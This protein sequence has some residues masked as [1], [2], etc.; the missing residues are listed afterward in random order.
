M[1]EWI[2][3]FPLAVVLF[4]NSALPLHI[5]EQRYKVLITRSAQKGLEFGINC[6]NENSM[7]QTGCTATVERILQRYEDGRMD[8]VV[9]GQRRYKL[10]QVD[11]KQEVYLVG[12][13]EFTSSVEDRVDLELARATIGLYHTLV[14]KAF[15]SDA[16]RFSPD[17]VGSGVSFLL[18]QKVGMSL[19]QRQRL[20]E[21]ATE[22]ERLGMLHQYLIEFLPKIQKA[23]DIERIIRNNG[24]L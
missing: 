23:E 1:K 14:E 5:F 18:A 24:Y 3:L 4:P 9:R 2:P 6:T 20:L 15:Q 13:V 11:A 10:H 12:L 8:I 7:A 22:N 17:E 21:L 16:H 19:D